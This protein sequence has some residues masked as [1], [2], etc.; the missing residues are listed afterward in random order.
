MR[1][2]HISRQTFMTV[3]LKAQ[4]VIRFLHL[5]LDLFRDGSSVD[6]FGWNSS[7]VFVNTALYGDFFCNVYA[8]ILI[9]YQLHFDFL[10]VF[11]L[12]LR[13]CLLCIR[14][15]VLL[16]PAFPFFGTNKCWAITSNNN[17]LCLYKTTLQPLCRTDRDSGIFCTAAT[18]LFIA[19]KGLSTAALNRQNLLLLQPA[20]L[21][22]F[23]CAS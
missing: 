17:I 20:L 19:V 22:L 12:L 2:H 11:T 18:V 21:Q 23:S 13:P 9:K 1:S 15:I 6:V 7:K 4:T 8:W 3:E 5:V 14:I 16:K 10:L